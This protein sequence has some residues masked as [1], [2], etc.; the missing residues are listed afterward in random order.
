MT[1]GTNELIWSLVI[2]GILGGSLAYV[3]WRERRRVKKGIPADP[4]SQ[5]NHSFQ[6]QMAA[7]ERLILLTE[8]IALPNVISRT[9]QPGVS[10]KDM[11]F[12]L[13]NTIRQEYEHNITQQIYVTPEAWEALRNLKEQNIHI[14]N[15]VASFLPPE[16][17]GTDLNKHLLEMIAAN[18]KVSLHSVVAEVL[19]FEAKKLLKQ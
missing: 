6:L 3:F 19:S 16:A 4:S 14:V 13:T 18:P 15:Q 7:Y 8:R 5:A 17:T 9:N 10:A 12:M 11:Q 2:A 1:L